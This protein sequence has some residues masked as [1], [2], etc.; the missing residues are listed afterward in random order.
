MASARIGELRPHQVENRGVFGAYSDRAGGG[1][2]ARGRRG[3]RRGTAT[4]E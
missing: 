2:V 3:Q 1:G 4:K